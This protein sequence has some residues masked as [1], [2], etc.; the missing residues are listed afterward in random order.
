[1]NVEIERSIEVNGVLFNA[2]DEAGKRASIDAAAAYLR[3][4]L[5]HSRI[6]W[7]YKGGHH[8]AVHSYFHTKRLAIVSE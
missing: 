4:R 2:L 3:D 6:Y 5:H 1:M 7:V 8:V